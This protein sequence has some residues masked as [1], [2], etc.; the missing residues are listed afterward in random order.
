MIASKTVIESKA[1]SPDTAFGL[2]AG[3]IITSR[4]KFQ[5]APDRGSDPQRHLHSLCSRNNTSASSVMR[6]RAVSKLALVRLRTKC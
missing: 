6:G 2:C 5:V 3:G 1:M 4:S